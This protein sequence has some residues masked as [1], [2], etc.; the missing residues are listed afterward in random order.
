MVSIKTPLLLYLALL[1]FFPLTTLN[2]IKVNNVDINALTEPG[3]W[4]AWGEFDSNNI[5][6]WVE[7]GNLCIG[8]ADINDALDNVSKWY[9]ELCT[10]QDQLKKLVSE[11]QIRVR[12]GSGICL[13]HAYVEGQGILFDSGT[14]L[15][16]VNSLLVSKEIVLVGKSLK[17]SG[18][19]IN[20]TSFV[21]LESN[22]PTSLIKMIRITF[23]PLITIPHFIQGQID[24]ETGHIADNFIVCG[25]KE[26]HILFAPEAFKH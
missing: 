4:A 1:L 18:C 11:N 24:F 23:D 14:D 6:F 12:A 19:Y 3:K 7:N 26:I 15:E 9:N 10:K 25:A 16:I 21:Q 2:A 8:V 13:K 17:L 20:D 22:A 5:S